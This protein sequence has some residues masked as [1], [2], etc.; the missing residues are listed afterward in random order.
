MINFKKTFFP[1]ALCV[2]LY[3]FSND[4][5]EVIASNPE[6]LTVVEQTT[7]TLPGNKMDAQVPVPNSIDTEQELVPDTVLKEAILTT[8]GKS[9]ASNLTKQDMAALI[10]LNIPSDKSAQISDLS[11]LEYAVNLTDLFLLTSKV[12]DFSPLEQLTN[13]VFVRLGGSSLTSDNFPDLKKSTGITHI[14]ASSAQLTNDVFPKLTQFPELQRLYLDSNIGITTIEPLKVLPK[15]RS[16]S[17]QF[18]GVTDF[19]VINAFPALND[20]AAFGQNTGRMNS[21]TTI[22]RSALTYNAEQETLFIPFSLMPDRLTNFDGYL[23]PFST[24]N[25]ANEM[26]LKFNGSQ[27]P[28]NRLQVSE[29]GITVLHVTPAESSNLST[30]YYNARINNPVGSY[31]TPPNLSFYSISAGTYLQNFTIVDDPIL[32]APVTINF[33]DRTGNDIVEPLILNGNI[34]EPFQAQPKDLADWIL[35]TSPDHAEGKFT[36]EA[37]ELTFIYEKAEGA[38]VTVLYTDDKDT[39]LAASD[40]LSGQLG[41]TYQ[42]QPK[43]IENYQLIQQIGHSEGTFTKQAQTIHYIYKK[44]ESVTVPSVDEPLISNVLPET[45]TVTQPLAFL[46][47]SAT[48]QTH[49]NQLPDKTVQTVDAIQQ[50]LLPETSAGFKKPR[51]AVNEK[52]A[53]K[54][55]DMN[56]GKGS[57]TVKFV[58]EKGNELA[59]SNTLT[60]K[61]GESYKVTA[62][63]TP[64]SK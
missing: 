45:G 32:G 4:P 44:V 58:D 33:R 31:A 14:S 49:T 38:A 1:S 20:L 27:L 17:I 26:I 6:D 21:A 50:P 30:M 52:K 10:S 3:L 16:I 2:G 55:D 48:V 46:S 37:Q 5:I 28:E 39:P 8:L 19:T 22:T 54:K 9:P 56:A 7:S 60:G 13:L 57:V 51:A 63:K 23:P 42:S 59:K 62:K 12:T 35:I 40:T 25:S 47:H 53:P 24:S 15:L 29:Q 18:C 64:R 11:G 43:S 41:A 34:D 61:I 36:Q